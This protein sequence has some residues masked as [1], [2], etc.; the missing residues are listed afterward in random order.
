MVLRLGRSRN[1]V[2]CNDNDSSILAF[3][4]DL[5]MIFLEFLE[6]DLTTVPALQDSVGT[7]HG[8]KNLLPRQFSLCNL[9][10]RMLAE[11]NIHNLTIS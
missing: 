4:D 7:C 8:F 3:N 1:P 9:E 10:I 6:Q 2:S 5:Q 11:D